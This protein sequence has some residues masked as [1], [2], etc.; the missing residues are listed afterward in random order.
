VR[1]AM[2]ILEYAPITGGAQRQLETVAPL[3]AQRGVDVDVLTRRSGALAAREEIGG[4]PVHRLAAP[5]PKATAS[6]GFTAAA[7]ARLAALRPDVIHAYSLFSPATIAVLAR[8]ALGTP[9]VVKVLRGGNG[10]DVERLRAKT[11]ASIRI[12]ALRAAID[13]FVAISDEIDTELAELGITSARRHRIPNGVDTQRFRPAAP[14]Q[15]AALRRRLALPDAPTVVYCGRLVREKRVDLL[16]ESWRALRER[17]SDVSLVIV[18]DGPEAPSLLQLA[19]PGVHFA[20]ACDDVVPYL[21]SG[22]AFV[23]PSDAE[24]LSNA[25]LEAMAVGLPIVATRVGAA[26]EVV[27]GC[28][29]GRL[30]PAGDA[31]A[32]RDALEATLTDPARTDLGARARARVVGAFGL[33]SVADRL[34]RLYET[35]QRPT[36]VGDPCTSSA[37]PSPGTEAPRN[38]FV[39]RRDARVCDP[40][41]GAEAG[42]R[43]GE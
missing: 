36:L 22:D 8:R 30:V 10:G 13:G 24:G 27:G 7:L 14:E 16:L 15:R 32:L 31:R 37:R 39:L 5:G 42:G 3:L 23:L 33:A 11:A 4:V 25:M 41:A 34:V 9:A 19:G 38:H 21:Q 43:H 26:A 20:G 17:R 6:L 28:G 35:V 1:V 12:R 29:A 2:V 18:G 40:R